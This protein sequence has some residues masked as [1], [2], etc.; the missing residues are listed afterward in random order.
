MVRRVWL[1]LAVTTVVSAVGYVFVGRLTSEPFV[2]FAMQ[3]SSLDE[4]SVRKIVER[5]Y[6]ALQMG[7]AIGPWLLLSGCFATGLIIRFR[8]RLDKFPVFVSVLISFSL[9]SFPCPVI[10]AAPGLDNSWQWLLN[11]LAFTTAFGRDTVFTYG[12]LGFLVCPQAP[13][14][15]VLVALGAN[16]CYA[17]VW[18]FVLAALY[19]SDKA[20]HSVSWLLLALTFFPQQNMEWRWV[21]LA[22]VSCFV[23][24]VVPCVHCR[25]FM[26]ASGG[27]VLALV[28]FMKFS[29]FVVVAATQVVCLGVMVLRERKW[30]QTALTWL[31][32]S[33]V[34]MF[35]IAFFSFESCRSFLCWV[36]G[37]IEIASGYNK[38][39]IS[40]K[41]VVELTVPFFVMAIVFFVQMSNASTKRQV[42]T[43]W[44]VFSPVFFC[45]T[46][47]ALVRQNPF[48]LFYLLSIFCAMSLC[49]LPVARRVMSVLVGVLMAATYVFTLPPAIAFYGFSDFSFGI[50]PKGIVETVRLKDSI[51]KAKEHSLSKVDPHRLPESWKKRIGK[52]S[53]T[54]LPHEFAPAMGVDH[55]NIVVLPSFQLYSACVPTI[56]L[57]NALMFRGEN[58]PKWIVCTIDPSWSGSCIGCPATWA[59]VRDCYHV[60]DENDGLVFLQRNNDTRSAP[61]AIGPVQMVVRVR[62]GEWIDCGGW[63]DRPSSIVWNQTMLGRACT[64]FLRNTQ[65]YLSLRYE[66]G[67][68]ATVPFPSENLQWPFILSDVAVSES[69]FV[70][71]LK[72]K[73]ARKPC[74]VRFW[75]ESRTLYEEVILIEIR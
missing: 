38:Y 45:T 49:A 60:V 56:D 64:L 62:A 32:T 25:T 2:S 29:M 44:L 24:V 73:H 5:S 6:F 52:D 28:T 33:L 3:H 35:A 55:Y 70:Q 63:A 43:L 50:N 26:L 42:L 40:P 36:K 22:V 34:V 16:V 11:Q 54:F 72:N 58:A 67:S 57:A 17:I 15:N 37:S 59:A 7:V 21:S 47:Y 61:V 46:K 74:Q 12:P 53:V 30:H 14:A 27:L 13:L 4:L 8:S 71:V 19:R 66:D 69:D 41:S 18:G 75:A 68:E 39:M 10:P 65:T 9:L 51:R 1:W 20:Y 31:A 48:P 23:P